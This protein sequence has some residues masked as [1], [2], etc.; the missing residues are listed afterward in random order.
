MAEGNQDEQAFARRQRVRLALIWYTQA[1]PHELPA[2]SC[3]ILVFDSLGGQHKTVIKLLKLYLMDE[4]RDKKQV[5]E[6]DLALGPPPTASPSTRLSRP[7]GYDCGLYAIHNID[8]FRRY[9]KRAS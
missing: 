9:S 4:A 6:G 3:F 5:P 1:A 7:N 8:V 2:N